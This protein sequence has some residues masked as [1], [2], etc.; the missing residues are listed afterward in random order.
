MLIVTVMTHYHQHIYN[1][2][3]QPHSVHLRQ[4]KLMNI[5]MEPWERYSRFKDDFEPEDENYLPSRRGKLLYECLK[6]SPSLDTARMYLRN[7]LYSHGKDEYIPSDLEAIVKNY[8]SL[9]F[10][11]PIS[12]EFKSWWAHHGVHVF[13]AKLATPDIVPITTLFSKSVLD[14]D[15]CIA[16]AQEYAE[17]KFI[18]SGANEA[19]LIA[20]PLIGDTKSIL[21]N[22]ERLLQE[23]TIKSIKTG[24]PSEILVGERF[25]ADTIT[26]RLRIL[27]MKAMYP[28]IPYHQLGAEAAIS[29]KYPNWETLAKAI[30]DPKIK[31]P[32]ASMEKHTIGA[33]ME[34]VNTIENAARGRF[35]MH[36]DDLLPADYD[37][38]IT[39][40]WIS[41]NIRYK[42][43]LIEMTE[44]Y[45]KKLLDE[46]Q[47]SSIENEE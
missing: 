16:K 36:T 32:A 39:L 20:V 34:A 30:I 23:Q 6:L 4:D 11:D 29:N 28:D 3:Y 21:K 24:K 9:G 43:H 37:Y 26:K 19:L 40:K 31:D 18:E 38:K 42:I 14:K 8:Q 13:G 25:S 45:K 15:M 47:S 12:S 22:I 33:L 41:E 17:G 1:L 44:H 2:N 35:P 7:H 27:W 10:T 5:K 46:Q